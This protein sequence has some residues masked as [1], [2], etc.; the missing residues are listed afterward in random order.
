M[1]VSN[2]PSTFLT[3]AFPFMKSSTVSYRT[4]IALALCTF[5]YVQYVAI[6]KLGVLGYLDHLA[7]EPRDVIG[8]CMVPLMLP[9]HIIQELLAKPLSLSLRLFGNVLGEDILIGTFV[10]MGI[11]VVG[12]IGLQAIPIGLPIQ[13]FPFFLARSKI[14]SNSSK[15]VWKLESL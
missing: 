12:A 6:T 5:F 11:A 8:W 3:L 13:I 7:G 1:T 2:G 4:T 9:M 15:I 10:G 14:T